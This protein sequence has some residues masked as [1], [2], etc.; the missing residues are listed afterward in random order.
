MFS[1]KWGKKLSGERS[2]KIRKSQIKISR[3]EDFG[4]DQQGQSSAQRE[5][6]FMREAE[7][8]GRPHEP[9]PEQDRGVFPVL[10]PNAFHSGSSVGLSPVESKDSVADGKR[11]ES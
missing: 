5:N 2:K 10:D 1:G 9:C 8:P 11:A 4:L 3:T 7:E 6:E